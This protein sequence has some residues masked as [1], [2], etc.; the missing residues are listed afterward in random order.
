MFERGH[1][2]GAKWVEWNKVVAADLP[3]D[4]KA[5][6]IFYCAN[7]WCSASHE[8]ARLAA[9][10]GYQHVFLM[11]R[12]ILGWKKAGKPVEAAR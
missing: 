9:G 2:P 7:E 11:P 5:S 4:R 8:S 10:F 3:S 6:L 1:V 12:G